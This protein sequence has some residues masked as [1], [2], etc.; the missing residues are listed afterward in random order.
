MLENSAASKRTHGIFI[1]KNGRGIVDGIRHGFDAESACRKSIVCTYPYSWPRDK[2]PEQ[3]TFLNWTIPLLFPQ[4]RYTH[5]RATDPVSC[6]CVPFL[7]VYIP[8]PGRHRYLLADVT[9][10]SS[11]APS[12]SSVYILFSLN[13]V[14]TPVYS[15][16]MVIISVTCEGI[17]PRP[18]ISSILFVSSSF[19][20][21]HF[22]IKPFISKELNLQGLLQVA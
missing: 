5:S 19:F 9:L 16:T 10:H 4:N 8:Q 1:P 22:V 11:A 20:S 17:I 15:V 12:N 18:Y 14:H 21:F 7:Q 3:A 13:N 2:D 6:Q